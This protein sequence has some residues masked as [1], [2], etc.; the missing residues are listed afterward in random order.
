MYVRHAYE[1]ILQRTMA[2]GCRVLSIVPGTLRK[3]SK[4]VSHYCYSLEIENECV[5]C[6]V[7]D[8]N[9]CLGKQERGLKK[10]VETISCYCTFP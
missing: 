2:N 8:N 5:V 1:T 3:F 7:K 9:F 6:S 4:N 10:W